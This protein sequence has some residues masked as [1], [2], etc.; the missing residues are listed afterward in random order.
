[1]HRKALIAAK[2]IS[3]AVSGASQPR[4]MKKISDNTCSRGGLTPAPGPKVPNRGIYA[5]ILATAWQVRTLMLEVT[6]NGQAMED[7]R[8][9]TAGIDTTHTHIAVQ[10]HSDSCFIARHVWSHAK[11]F[12][13][14]P[15]SQT[16]L[17]P[18]QGLSSSHLRFASFSVSPHHACAC[19]TPRRPRVKEAQ[20]LLS[21]FRSLLWVSHDRPQCRR[22]R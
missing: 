3:R 14:P 16:A 17:L 4:A 6:K 20:K 21:G 13:H 1:M 5:L 19:K 8:P 12:Y 10:A 7:R 22:R 15:F 11:S 2:S 9:C 18:C